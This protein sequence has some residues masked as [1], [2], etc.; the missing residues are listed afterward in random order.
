ML[1]GRVWPLEGR[2]LVRLGVLQSRA[3]SSNACLADDAVRIAE[4]H[5]RG[6]GLSADVAFAGCPGCRTGR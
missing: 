2:D 4:L 5:D 6:V 1:L 3:R